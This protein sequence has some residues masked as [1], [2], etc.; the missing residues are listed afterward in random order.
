MSEETQS[1]KTT[2]VPEPKV[3]SESVN[4]PEKAPEAKKA[5]VKIE[6]NAEAKVIA[7]GTEAQ[8]SESSK[9]KPLSAKDESLSTAQK[10]KLNEE[11]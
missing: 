2:S 11:Y 10:Q 5:E 3:L 1:S 6:D 7:K 9:A 4:Q 8:V